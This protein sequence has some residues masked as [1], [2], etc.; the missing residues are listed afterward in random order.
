MPN[1]DLSHIPKSPLSASILSRPAQTSISAGDK[2]LIDDVGKYGLALHD[3]LPGEMVK[4]LYDTQGSVYIVAPTEP[5][6]T[7]FS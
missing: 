3:A 4:I 6:W 5:L 7:P 2:I 1:F